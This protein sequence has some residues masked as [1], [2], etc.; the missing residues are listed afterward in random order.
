MLPIM[1]KGRIKNRVC[2][3]LQ[4]NQNCLMQKMLCIAAFCLISFVCVGTLFFND[5]QED[6]SRT[7]TEKVHDDYIA[8]N[9]FFMEKSQYYKIVM[10]ENGVYVFENA[11]KAFDVMCLQCQKGIALIQDEFGLEALSRKN[12]VEY[13]NLGSQ[14]TGGSEDAKHQADFVAIFLDIYENSE[15]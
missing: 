13:K 10:D 12:Y 5:G 7:N 2:A 11:S 15:K 3:I 1:K 14:V 8:Q 4:K 6:E 9:D